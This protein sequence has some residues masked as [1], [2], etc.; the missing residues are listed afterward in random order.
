MQEVLRVGI[1]VGAHLHYVGISSPEGVLLEEFSIPHH[2]K[3][4]EQFFQRVEHHRRGLPVAVAMEVPG[5][6]SIRL[7]RN[8]RSLGYY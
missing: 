6:S 3:G 2:E 5:V 7:T 1:D 4:F 8:P